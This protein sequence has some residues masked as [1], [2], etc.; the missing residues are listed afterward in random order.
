MFS[1][2]HVIK[3][4]QCMPRWNNTERAN[5]LWTFSNQT[6]SHS[7]CSIKF[8]AGN[9]HTCFAGHE[10]WCERE[11]VVAAH[12]HT[13]ANCIGTVI[14]A[15][16]HCQPDC[17]SSTALLCSTGGCRHG[18]AGHE[19]AGQGNTDLAN[20]HCVAQGCPDILFFH[21]SEKRMGASIWPEPFHHIIRE[22]SRESLCSHQ[23]FDEKKA[24]HLAS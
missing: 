20:M 19:H 12:T 9:R 13:Y 18:S 3:C 6:P 4:L 15:A 17:H 21:P 7:T 10:C 22:V 1:N 5:Q 16:A 23:F 8:A 24:Y 11:T 14:A 2:L